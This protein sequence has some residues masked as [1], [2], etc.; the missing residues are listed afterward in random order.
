MR[1]R[2][3]HVNALLAQHALRF[4]RTSALLAARQQMIA[5]REF[6]FCINLRTEI[7]DTV[8]DHDFCD[9]LSFTEK[10]AAAPELIV[11]H[12]MFHDDDEHRDAL[13]EKRALPHVGLSPRLYVSPAAARA[14]RAE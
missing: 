13:I 1:R 5:A 9:V 2:S 10:D 11:T 3:N 6:C 14:M 7:L 4:A 12:F 8:S